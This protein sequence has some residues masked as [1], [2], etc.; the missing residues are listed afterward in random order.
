MMP[1]DKLWCTSSVLLS[2][3]TTVST[4]NLGTYL[5]RG[6]LEDCMW[7]GRAC[8]V[9]GFS[10]LDGQTIDRSIRLSVNEDLR[11]PARQGQSSRYWESLGVGPL[12]PVGDKM[13][14]R[15]VQ[16]IAILV[17][18]RCE[19]KERFL[20]QKPPGFSFKLIRTHVG[21]NTTYVCCRV[22]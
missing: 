16:I 14:T 1:S 8:G 5:G 7:A 13:Y 10:P 22:E 3:S 17:F 20:F 21:I 15:I 9:Q 2:T 11:G 12:S 18:C 4:T 19:K 6:K